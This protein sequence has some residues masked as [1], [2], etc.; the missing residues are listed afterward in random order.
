MSARRAATSKGLFD[1]KPVELATT[2]CNGTIATILDRAAE[3]I[4]EY[5][6]FVDLFFDVL[7]DIGN[8]R[9]RPMRWFFKTY[10]TQGRRIHV[11][12]ADC[13]NGDYLA[14]SL[15]ID[16]DLVL[17]SDWLDTLAC[18]YEHHELH[19]T[20]DGSRQ[21]IAL[22]VA[23]VILHELWHRAEYWMWG[24]GIVSGAAP[25]FGKMHILSHVYGHPGEMRATAFDS[26]FK[27]LVK[28]SEPTHSGQLLGHNEYCCPDV[29]WLDV[30]DVFLP[31]GLTFQQ[32]EDLGHKKRAGT[33]CKGPPI[34]EWFA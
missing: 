6:H 24:K 1:D 15:T 7:E 2:A 33:R 3:L 14:H 20:R 5:K 23:T 10:L 18:H 19:D 11:K 13:G 31:L 4:E 29:Y 21:C 8:H 32:M 30:T 16:F 25:M 34:N 22:D 26:W 12:C 27:Y 17:C 28:F 9:F